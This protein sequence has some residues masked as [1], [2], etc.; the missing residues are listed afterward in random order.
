MTFFFLLTAGVSLTISYATLG[1]GKRTETR[2][3]QLFSMQLKP[4]VESFN[5]AISQFPCTNLSEAV[6][7]GVCQL[8]IRI[9]DGLQLMII[10]M[11]SVQCRLTAPHQ[12]DPGHSD[13]A[14]ILHRTRYYVA[15]RCV[16]VERYLFDLHSP[17]LND[18]TRLLSEC[19]NLVPLQGSMMQASQI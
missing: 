10:N 3:R 14:C 5:H 8:R 11:A 17:T 19:S 2:P 13:V 18:I 6:T 12:D 4:L 7:V 16:Y 15:L 1:E 9:I